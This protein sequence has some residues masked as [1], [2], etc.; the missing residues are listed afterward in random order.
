VDLLVAIG[1]RHEARGDRPAS[2]SAFREAL[3]ANG[4]TCPPAEEGLL[5]LGASA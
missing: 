5:R 3:V 2:A 4:G 1:E